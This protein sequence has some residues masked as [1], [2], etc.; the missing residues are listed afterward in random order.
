MEYAVMDARAHR[1]SHHYCLG[2]YHRL[3]R[4]LMARMGSMGLQYRAIQRTW[5]D[6]SSIHGILDSNIVDG[7]YLG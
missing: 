3:Y 6:L 2:I 5:P 7:N 1:N 4:E